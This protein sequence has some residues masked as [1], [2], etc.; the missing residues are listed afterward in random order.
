MFVRFASHYALTIW[1]SNFKYLGPVRSVFEP[2]LSL[3][4]AYAHTQLSTE[5][6]HIFPIPQLSQSPLP[7]PH[8]HNLPHS[9]NSSRNCLYVGNLHPTVDE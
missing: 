4:S 5:C 8:S 7:L 3:S 6:P 1:I 2:V 9:V